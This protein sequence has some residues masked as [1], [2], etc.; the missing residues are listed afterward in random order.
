MFMTDPLP[1]HPVMP[2]KAGI[3]DFCAKVSVFTYDFVRAKTRT[4]KI[5]S[6]GASII[7]MLTMVIGTPA[8]AKTSNI[9]HYENQESELSGHIV[10][11]N[12]WNQ[13]DFY[14]GLKHAPQYTAVAIFTPDRPINVIATEK[15]GPDE[16]S[17]YNA[18]KIEINVPDPNKLKKILRR[19]VRVSGQLYERTRGFEYTDVL[20]S[21]DSVSI[22][23]D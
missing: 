9:Y 13:A 21:L 2:A 19:H 10:F 8:C 16:D 6:A 15:S 1:I 12:I 11:K 4:M 22:E 20:L 5:M 23:R 3:H 18:R 17:F 14:Y 7:S